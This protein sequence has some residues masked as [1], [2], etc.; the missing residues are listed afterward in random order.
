MPPK[1]QPVQSAEAFRQSK[2]D[3]INQIGHDNAFPHQFHIDLNVSDIIERY[4]DKLKDTK[5]QILDDTIKTAGRIF[6]IRTAGKK[7]CFIDIGNE[8][9]KLQVLYRCTLQ[10]PT[11]EDFEVWKKP[12]ANL[13]RGDIVGITG[14]MG[15]SSTGELSLY[16][17]E[18]KILSVCMHMIPQQLADHEIQQRQRTLHFIVNHQEINTFKIRHKIIRYMR[19]YF[20]TQGFM[21]VETPMLNA[22]PGGAAA[23][24]FITKHNALNQQ[25][26]MRIAPELYLK[27]LVMGG[28]DRVYEIGKQFRNE[29]VDRTHNPEFSSIETYCAY[30]DYYDMMDM[31]E[32]LLSRMTMVLF[33][34]ND[35]VYNNQTISF[36]PPFQRLRIIPELEARLNIKFDGMDF[37]SNEFNQFLKDSCEKN[38]VECTPPFTTARL[39]DSLIAHYL[40][41]LCTQPTFICDHPRIMSP[42]AKWHRDDPRLTERFELFVNK[43]E[44]CNAY[45][46]LNDPIVQ[47]EA[48]VDQMKNR[49]NGDDESMIIDET[50]LKAMEHGLPPTAGWGMGID[51]LVMFLT[52]KQNIQSVLTFPLTRNI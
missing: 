38:S 51:R 29:D 24:P 13:N 47:R 27:M 17:D 3:Y 31:T 11:P 9:S 50:Y 5:N 22:I 4:K 15:T 41:P 6:S 37:S 34:T 44:L 39:F 42:L 26:Y 23:K 21:E 32:Q 45:T 35:I 10:N 40:E 7:L 20:D 48:F 28:M 16:P 14:H 36:K 30:Q 18:I 52:D 33:K 46:E 19:N 8:T 49:S 1:A 12:V 25:M 2:L 43:K